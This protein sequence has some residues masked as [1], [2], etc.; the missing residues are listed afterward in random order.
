MGERMAAL[1]AFGVLDE[2]VDDRTHVV[3]PSGEVDA[4]TAPVL[5][6]RLLGLVGQGKTSLIVDLSKVTFMDSTGIGV[7]INALRA[8]GRREGRL[9]LVCP[10]ERILRPFEITGLSG[11]LPIVSSREEA[12][13]SLSAA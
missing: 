1:P 13:G 3:A 5:G 6:G 8:L 11:Y 2:S 4:L 7:L 12:L 10:T 9:V